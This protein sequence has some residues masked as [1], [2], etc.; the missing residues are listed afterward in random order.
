MIGRLFLLPIV[1]SLLWCLFLT[2]NGY[3]LKQGKKGFYGIFV[4]CGLVMAF[5]TL[6][7][8]VTNPY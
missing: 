4:F 8:W 6:M 2:V 1:L 7:I 5:F 3:S